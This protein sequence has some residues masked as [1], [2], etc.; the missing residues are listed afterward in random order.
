V[1]KSGYISEEKDK[2]KRDVPRAVIDKS[3]SV[4][5]LVEVWVQCDKEADP[6]VHAPYSP[7][8]ANFVADITQE[9]LQLYSTQ[10]L[11]NEEKQQMVKK[12]KL[13]EKDSISTAL[14]SSSLFPWTNPLLII[15]SEHDY[16]T[17]H[18]SSKMFYDSYCPNTSNSSDSDGQDNKIEG[19]SSPALTFSE[20]EY[21]K[22]CD[23]RRI[24]HGFKYEDYVLHNPILE[25]DS[26]EETKELVYSFLKKFNNN[27]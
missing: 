9:M 6:L 8:Y 15:H 2:K 24:F 22:Y 4:G 20:K 3:I 25:E 5:Q 19:P 14:S 17:S 13:S 11:I 1:F 12:M 16:T 26:K 10:K 21:A 23:S 7:V 27:L 18:R